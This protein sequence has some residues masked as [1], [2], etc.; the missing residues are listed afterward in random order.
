[1]LLRRDIFIFEFL[2]L[3][4]FVVFLHVMLG[5]L[6][7]DEENIAYLILKEPNKFNI[8]AMIQKS[9]KLLIAKI[10]VF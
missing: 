3:F 6:T 10:P 4:H 8:P 7:L 2:S 5:V 9:N 1:M